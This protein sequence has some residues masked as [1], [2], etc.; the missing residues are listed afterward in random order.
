MEIENHYLPI[1]IR[2]YIVAQVESGV[3]YT[4]IVE[5]VQLKHGKKVSKGT[6]TKIYSKFQETGTIEDLPKSGR[7][8]IYTLDQEMEI[9]EAV[10]NDRKLTSVDIARD[11]TLNKSNVTDRTIQNILNREGLFARTTQPIIISEASIEKRL[12]FANKYIAQPQVWPTIVF[13]DESDLFPYKS[14]KLFIRRYRGEKP[15][16]YYAMYTK[17]DPRTVKVW[18]CISIFGVGPLVRYTE[19]MKNTD[20]IPI[21]EN[22]LLKAFPKLRGTS[23]RKGA[24]T[25][26]QDN[27]KPHSADNVKEWFLNNHVNVMEWPSYSP[28]LN[29]I[30]NLW[31]IL[32]DRLYDDNHLLETADDVWKKAQSIWYKDLNVYI[33][34]LYKSMPFRIEEVLE[35]NGNRLDQ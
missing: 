22:Y 24:L 15:L 10:K 23:S 33:E 32:Q 18:G 17:W 3:S 8:H 14:G 31:G 35:R 25:F 9:V 11:P 21:L 2:S 29:P 6:I 13:S 16:D 19:T 34:D 4:N 12:A 7:P 1:H 27:A 30:E 5:K 20:Y 26:Q 28:D